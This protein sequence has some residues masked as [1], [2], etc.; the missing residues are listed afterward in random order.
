MNK[1]NL[2][3][4]GSGVLLLL[5]TAAVALPAQTRTGVPPAQTFTVLHTFDLSDGA[6]P[7]AP[8]VQGTDGSF[9]G[10]TEYGG[11][12][13]D[14]GTAFSITPAGTVTTLYTFWYATGGS[15]PRA[16]LV[17]GADGSF[18]GTTYGGGNPIC[19][20][21]SGCGTVFNLAADKHTV[22]TLHNFDGTDGQWLYAGLVL[23]ANGTFYGA[24]TEGG[25]NGNGTVFSIT[26]RGTLTTLHNFNGTDGG[27]PVGGLVRG[28]DGKFYGTTVAGGLGGYCLPHQACGTIFSITADGTFTTLYNF[29]SQNNCADGAWPNAS[30]IQG[31]DGSFYGTTYTGG[32]NGGGTIFRITAGGAFTTSYNFCSQPHCA[33]GESPYAGLVQGTDGSFYGTTEYGGVNVCHCGTVFSITPGGTL[34]TLHTFDNT[35]GAYPYGGL[36]QG[37]NGTFYGTAAYGGAHDRGVVFSLSVGLGAFVEIQPTSGKVGKAVKILGTNLNGASNVTFNGTPATFVVKSKSLITTT[38][39][40]GATTGRVWVTF[41]HGRRSSNVPFRVTP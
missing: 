4:R 38:V 3:L 20:G 1:F 6:S 41:P 18:Y 23:A 32:A 24:T 30:L 15:Y 19:N 9:Y 37:T 8:L 36:V 35:D 29:C 34:T 39:P 11:G 14:D 31:T 26:A 16:G 25:A 27:A 2:W 28:S 13:Y 21:G 22:K 10:T 12:F 40:S 17:E 7:Q 5:A 33:D